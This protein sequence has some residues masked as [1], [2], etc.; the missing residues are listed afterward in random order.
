MALVDLVLFLHSYL[1]AYNINIVLNQLFSIYDLSTL[2][3][4]KLSYWS[5][6]VLP[7]IKN[8][9]IH[10]SGSK[11]LIAHKNQDHLFF[12]LTSP[13]SESQPI[14]CLCVCVCVCV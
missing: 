14:V 3:I 9:Y 1:L 5:I 11:K 8:L 2:E 10:C 12:P 4:W 6:L 7:Y 13:L